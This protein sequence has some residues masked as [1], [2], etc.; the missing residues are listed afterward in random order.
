MP[1]TPGRARDS[2]GIDSMHARVCSLQRCEQ[3]SLGSLLPADNHPGPHVG[4]AHRGMLL[5]GAGPSVDG[6]VSWD[7]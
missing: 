2:L 3:G 1:D 7:D 4:E 6:F 5:D